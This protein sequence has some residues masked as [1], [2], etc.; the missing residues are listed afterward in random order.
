MGLIEKIKDDVEYGLVIPLSIQLHTFTKEHQD[1]SKPRIFLKT[2]D[3]EGFTIGFTINTM[4]V[5]TY[6]KKMNEIIKKLLE[7]KYSRII[8][9]VELL[10]ESEKYMKLLYMAE[11][12][13]I[14]NSL[15]LKTRRSEE[16]IKQ[17]PPLIIREYDEKGFT[18]AC[19]WNERIVKIE[20][21][22]NNEFLIS[23]GGRPITSYDL[24]NTN[25]EEVLKRLF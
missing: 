24:K 15:Y 5:N 3:D 23:V 14:E 13:A 2:L 17:L 11:L 16:E 21:V 9:G 10:R 25:I 1:F 22:I 19:T 4:Y 12:D 8:E 6:G 7:N 20:K 18:V